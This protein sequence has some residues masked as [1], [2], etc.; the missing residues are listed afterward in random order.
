MNDVIKKTLSGIAKAQRD[1]EAWSDGLW[2][3]AAPEYMLTMY[4]AKELRTKS[5]PTK[6]RLYLTLESD[7]RGALEDAGG[8]GRG[9]ISEAARLGG[10]SDIMLWRSSNDMPRVVIE[11]K[12]SVS[13]SATEIKQDVDRISTMLRNRDNS[14]R[15]GLV[16]FYTSVRDRGGDGGRA[17]STIRKRLKKIE[18][19]TRDILQGNRI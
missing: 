9:K 5:R 15:R 18:Q 17:K 3:W 19:E 8:M 6:S 14:F 16:A 13:G 12:R 11:V 4:I 1:Y 2:L 7:V 10:R